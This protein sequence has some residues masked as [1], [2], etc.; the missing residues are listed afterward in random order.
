M[1]TN[2][3]GLSNFSKV[4]THSQYQL[5]R[6]LAALQKGSSFSQQCS[7]VPVS[8]IFAKFVILFLIIA[9]FVGVKLYLIVVF[10]CISMMIHDVHLFMCCWLFVYLLWGNVYSDIWLILKFSYCSFYY[11]VAYI[12]LDI[13]PI[14][15]IWFVNIFSHMWVVCSGFCAYISFWVDL[16]VEL[17]SQMVTLCLTCWETTKQN[18]CTFL[19][20]QQQCMS[21]SVSPYPCQHLVLFVFL[22]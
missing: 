21:V 13:S 7:G 4:T 5:T 19:Q 6:V 12:F 18:A 20:S 2:F 8:P 11:W 14:S 16:G 15:D 10:I 22:I 9:I 1:V 17:L 3:E